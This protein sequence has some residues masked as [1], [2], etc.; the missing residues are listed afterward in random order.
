V[1]SA[2]RV[3]L[4]RLD[5]NHDVATF[6]SGNK[7]LDTWLRRHALAAQ[8][9]GSA[10][11]FVATRGGRVVGYFSLTMGSVLRAQAPATLV[12]GT[13]AYPVGMVL[14]ARLAVDRAQQG[15][16]IG[17]MLLAEALRKAVAAGEVAAARLIVVDA[18]DEDAAAFYR[19]YGFVQTPENPLRFYRHMKD[20][21]ASLDSSAE[22]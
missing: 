3:L 11:T 6:D 8:R 20:V 17:A 10:R 13:P 2:P 12:R 21:R 19:R 22:Q 14:L 16:G 9:M 7:V 1:S 15:R 18:V 5:A 4:D